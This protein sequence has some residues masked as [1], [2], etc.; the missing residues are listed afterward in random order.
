MSTESISSSKSPGLKDAVQRAGAVRRPQMIQ[1]HHDLACQMTWYNPY[2]RL[3]SYSGDKTRRI[4]EQN[5][6]C[7][8]KPWWPLYSFWPVRTSAYLLGMLWPKT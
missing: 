2:P 1:G 5:V 8:L 4:C 3:S 7:E 6:T